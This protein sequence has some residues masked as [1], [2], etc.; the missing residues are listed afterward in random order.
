MHKMRQCLYAVLLVLVGL[1]GLLCYL[2]GNEQSELVVTPRIEGNT[3]N[4]DNG[5]AD[6]KKIM[7][8]DSAENHVLTKGIQA[9][10]DKDSTH[11][12]V[13]IAYPQEKREPYIYQSEAMKSASMIKVF[14][15]AAAMEKVKNG[16][17]ALD[18][19]VILHQE[20]KTGG[21]GILSGY[22]NESELSLD[23]VLRLMITES[24]NTATN[25]LIDL[26]GM[27]NINDYIRRNG[28]SDTCLARKMMDFAAARA[29]RENYTSVRDLGDL[30]GRIYRH[31]CID[32]EQDEIMLSYLRDQEDREC[33][34]AALPEAVIAHKTGELEGLYD[35]GGIIYLDDRA[36]IVVIMTENYSKRHTAIEIMREMVR[37]AA[38]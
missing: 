14:L 9:L 32:Y 15:L 19:P 21:S 16:S 17:L 36:L 7:I 13:Y 37:L 24:D 23:T 22:N 1:T 12:S 18:M 11:Y 10:S 26:L 27:E 30:F 34:P 28:Y 33:F 31:E 8:S 4:M 5:S 20:D 35:D 25:I 6:D 29:G 2:C 38:E 3:E